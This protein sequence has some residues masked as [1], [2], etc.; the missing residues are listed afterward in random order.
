M[1]DP[2]E[3]LNDPL[4]LHQAGVDDRRRAIDALVAQLGDAWLA[5][6]PALDEDSL[7]LVHRPTGLTFVAVPG[8]EFEMG[9]SDEDI[10]EASEHVDWTSPV[11]RWIDNAAASARPV[12]RVNV[13]PFL[14]ARALLDSARI[15]ASAD[16]PLDGE[17]V[18]RSDALAVARA[19]GFRLPSEA[20]LEWLSRDGGAYRFTLDAARQFG[21]VDGDDRLLRSRFGVRDL[22]RSQWAEDDWHPTYDGAP[23]TSL[24][25][26]DGDPRGVYRGGFHLISLQSREELLH[27]L[28]AVRG[29][30]YRACCVRLAASI[31]VEG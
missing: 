8:G 1:V 19:L 13:R 16:R 29:R 24:P 14:C 28:A 30:I 12:H 11:A 7:P 21:A 23:A 10:E 18:Q 9:L 27:A 4:A 20:E 15:H 17:S 2:T 25:W 26:G 6:Q 22:H 3:I 31:P 5:D